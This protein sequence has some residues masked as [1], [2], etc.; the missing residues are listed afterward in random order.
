MTR[1]TQADLRQAFASLRRYDFGQSTEPLDRIDTY[2]RTAF[3]QPDLRPAIEKEL[4]EAL[5]A[6]VPQGA[7]KFV[8]Q[9]L[10]SLGTDAAS[11]TI[12]RKLAH[13]DVHVVEAACFAIAQRPSQKADEAIRT[14]LVGAQGAAQIALIHL[15]GGRRDAGCVPALAKLAVSTDRTLAVAAESALGKIASPDALAALSALRTES[16]G[17]ALLQAAQELR[18][19]QKQF[20]ARD[21]LRRLDTASSSI[22]VRRGASSLLASAAAG[23]DGF[24]P[25]FNGRNLSDFVVDTASVWSVRNGV[26][27]GRSPGLKYNE[28]LRTKEQYQDFTL[29]ARLRMI[30][31]VGNSGFQFRSKAVPDSHEVEGYQADAGQRFWGALYDESRRKKILAAP[32]D[33]FLDALD[34][35]IWHTYVVTAQGDHIRIE[36]DGVR[37]VDYREPEPGIARSGFIA[38]QVHSHTAPVEMWFRDL[39]IKLL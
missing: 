3:A 19:R 29:H 33:R 20:E 36:L 8:C 38:L 37:T 23:D 30:D 12:G 18:A 21:L 10:W 14:A 25:L 28:F 34:P 9:K 27:I 4:I 31:G 2:I 39:R 6:G 11:G 24:R 17:L 7:M 16:A 26:I 15:A 5:D 35:T 32:D 1:I 13:R 22:L